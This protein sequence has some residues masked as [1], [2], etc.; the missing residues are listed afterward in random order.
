MWV[1]ATGWSCFKAFLASG[2]A[3][4]RV[5]LSRPP[6]KECAVYKVTREAVE[7]RLI[8]DRTREGNVRVLMTPLLD[9]QRYARGE[10]ATS[11]TAAGG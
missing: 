5:R 7:V 6:A 9:T 1:Y 3:E 10:S 11:T 2:E 8:C 4:R